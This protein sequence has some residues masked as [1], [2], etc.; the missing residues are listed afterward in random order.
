MPKKLLDSKLLY[1]IFSVVM[2]FTLWCYVTTVEGVTDT[3]VISNIPVEFE[4]EDIL[5]LCRVALNEAP[6]GHDTNFQ[7]FDRI[8]NFRYIHEE[9]TV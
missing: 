1:V 4:G 3:E 5:L 6:N 8:E 7:I 2:A 9:V